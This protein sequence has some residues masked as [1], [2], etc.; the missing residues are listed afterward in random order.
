MYELNL[1]TTSW[2][3]IAA[4][5]AAV[6][7]ALAVPAMPTRATRIR[8]SSMPVVLAAAVYVASIAHSDYSTQLLLLMYSIACLALP[9]CL[10]GFRKKMARLILERPADGSVPLE[11]T[12]LVR[13]GMIRFT[14]A[15]V[16][17][18]GVL[19][20]IKP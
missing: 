2:W 18:G 8:M 14:L 5:C 10:L 12:G 20:L 19:Y 1:S 16:A 11:H 3:L 4:L 15:A 9:G 6:N 17:V 7:L 13:E